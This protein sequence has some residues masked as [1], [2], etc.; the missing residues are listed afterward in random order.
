MEIVGILSCFQI[1]DDGLRRSNL[2]REKRRLR[3]EANTENKVAVDR[4]VDY[5]P[6]VVDKPYRQQVTEK[7]NV[8]NFRQAF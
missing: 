6:R 4:A 5:T 7:A 3:R 8:S 2:I 1:R